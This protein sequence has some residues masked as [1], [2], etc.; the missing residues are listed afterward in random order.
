MTPE[1][2]KEKEVQSV[3]ITSEDGMTHHYYMIS[4]S[5]L[6][7]SETAGLRKMQIAHDVTV[8]FGELL[9]DPS[10]QVTKSQPQAW[11]NFAKANHCGT[12]RPFTKQ[13]AVQ[14][15]IK[16]GKPP[17]VLSVQKWRAKAESILKKRERDEAGV[18]SDNSDGD[19]S[20]DDHLADMDDEGEG[21][22]K[23]AQLESTEALINAP[24]LEAK[25]KAAAKRRGKKQDD[26]DD[27]DLSMTGS[28]SRVMELAQLDPDMS[29]VAAKHEQLTGRGTPPCLFALDIAKAFECNGKIGQSINGV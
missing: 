9:L 19:Q 14:N 26:E 8:Q 21:R 22:P 2:K 15:Q 7:A 28:Q 29:K 6:D 27:E 3:S 13:A 25:R 4:L 24:K 11:F 5:G 20:D 18:Q 1:V 10:E 17:P 16:D 23:H 12:Q